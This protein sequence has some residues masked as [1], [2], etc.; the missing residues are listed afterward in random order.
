MTK[1]IECKFFKRFANPMDDGYG[2]GQCMFHP[3]VV[4]FIDN[5]Y[6]T[7]RFQARPAVKFGDYCALSVLQD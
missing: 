5:E 7:Q 6:D 2:D 3:P 1:C 4:Q